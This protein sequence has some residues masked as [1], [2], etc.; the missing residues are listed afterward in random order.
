MYRMR[1]SIYCKTTWPMRPLPVLNPVVPVWDWAPRSRPL[2]AYLHLHSKRLIP[3]HGGL[4]RI[5]NP[6]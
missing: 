3:A 6:S 1:T 5:Q 4:K 2:P